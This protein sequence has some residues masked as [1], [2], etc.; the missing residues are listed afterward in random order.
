MYVVIFL[1]MWLPLA[2]LQGNQ[3]QFFLVFRF[4]SPPNDSRLSEPSDKWFL[5]DRILFAQIGWLFRWLSS[6]K[7][8][9]V[10]PTRRRK[11]FDEFSNCF[12]TVFELFSSCFR[13]V[14]ELFSNCFRTVFELF[15]DNFRAV[16]GQFS[17][18]FRTV[19]EQFLA[20]FRQ[21]SDNFRAVFDQFLTSFELFSNRD[22]TL[23]LLFP[24]KTFPAIVSVTNYV[25]LYTYFIILW[26][27]NLFGRPPKIRIVICRSLPFDEM[28]V[29]QVSLR[30]T[31]CV[32]I[33][34]SILTI[35]QIS[36]RGHFFALSIKS[37]S[38]LGG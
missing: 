25:R 35:C 19:F 27:L 4:G 22:R 10:M 33:C 16:F 2:T 29:G 13:T 15:S 38:Q 28:S 31:V 12:R 6:S 23:K 1:R 30:W 3:L 9:A 5:C 20:I 36:E 37:V 21:N 14:F 24:I 32:H 8:V 11:V 7:M 18:C 26:F 34:C 17:N